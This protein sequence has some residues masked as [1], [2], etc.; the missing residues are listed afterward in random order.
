MNKNILL[1]IL[2]VGLNHLCFGQII[3]IKKELNEM[4][5]ELSIP[6]S[7]Y[8]VRKKLHSSANFSER[9]E[10]PYGKFDILDAEFKNNYK[11]SY[12]ENSVRRLASFWF[13]KGTDIN[14]SFGLEIH[15]PSQNVT[16]C[17]EQFKEVMNFFKPISYKTTLNPYIVDSVQRG[18]WF[19]AYSSLKSYQNNEAYLIIINEYSKIA[20][21][22]TSPPPG[23]YYNVSFGF[24]NKY[25]Y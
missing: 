10:Y 1:L 11:L 17:S 9:S 22:I 5:F 6:S 23:E 19:S 7:K 20:S 16:T 13:D 3:K 18:E 21:N 8:D 14:F 12:L 24:Y 4:L 15:Y 2:F 25:L